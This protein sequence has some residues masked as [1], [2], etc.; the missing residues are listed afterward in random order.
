MAA[1][2][3]CAFDGGS[4][5]CSEKL[6]PNS[7]LATARDQMAMGA[8]LGTGQRN[9]LAICPRQ[10][11]PE[12]PAAKSPSWKLNGTVELGALEHQ[13]AHMTRTGPI[14]WPI[15]PGAFGLRRN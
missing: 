8:R 9:S 1:K 13:P 10:Q 6:G 7:T 3:D 15:A 4:P 14:P 5:S 2:L 11:R 12:K